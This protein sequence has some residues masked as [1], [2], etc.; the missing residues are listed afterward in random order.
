M[1]WDDRKPHMELERPGTK[2]SGF[3]LW[4]IWIPLNNRLLILYLGHFF[5]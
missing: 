3:I 2:E 1:R 5:L 4:M